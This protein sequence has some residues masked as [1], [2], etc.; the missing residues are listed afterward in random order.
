MTARTAKKIATVAVATAGWLIASPAGAS[1]HITATATDT[2]PGAYSVITLRVPTESTTAGTI[3][4]EVTLPAEHP[5]AV[6]R[7]ETTPG[8][9]STQHT[10][11]LTEPIDTGHGGVVSEAVSAVTFTAQPG[12][13]IAPGEFAQFRLLVG[14]IP[15]AETLVLP[16]IQT[17]S[18]GTVVSWIEQSSDGTEP[19]KPAP[20][21]DLTQ[22]S[23]NVAGT[24]TAGQVSATATAADPGSTPNA[25]SS[26]PWVSWAALI[27]AIGAAVL[28]VYSLAVGRTR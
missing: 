27:A 21:L 17:Y 22:P 9:T 28:A 24:T 25:D 6:V 15:D 4:L 23:G 10:R 19:D 18:D 20:A 2:A 11:T 13:A 26:I 12:S 3:G 5:F 1:A 14:P 7:S 16:A 8:W